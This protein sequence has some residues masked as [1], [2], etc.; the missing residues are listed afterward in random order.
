MWWDVCAAP[1]HDKAAAFISPGSTGCSEVN[2]DLAE[3][4]N[5]TEKGSQ[6]EGGSPK[7]QTVELAGQALGALRRG[8]QE[9][10][11]GWTRS[12]PSGPSCAWCKDG[13][14]A[15]G[16]HS[17]PPSLVACTGSDHVSAL[18]GSGRV[19]VWA[20]GE[21]A[22]GASW[23]CRRKSRVALAAPAG[24]RGHGGPSWED[25]EEFV[26]LA[27]LRGGSPRKTVHL[28]F[29]SVQW[30]LRSARWES[31]LNRVQ[32]NKQAT[33]NGPTENS[34]ACYAPPIRH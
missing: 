2:R 8:E 7:L 18:Q 5:W 13:E 34:H 6:A 23:K 17:L 11:K 9:A 12:F 27:P 10:G 3:S 14:C 33:P 21:G 26:P 1:L 4:C 16:T 32:P 31:Q 20:C 24:S 15:W 19:L 25:L 28:L 29:G 30:H 22:S